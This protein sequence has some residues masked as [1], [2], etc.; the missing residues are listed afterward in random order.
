MRHILLASTVL[1]SGCG[2]AIPSAPS[3]DPQ[4]AV[5]PATMPA[6]RDEPASIPLEQC[7]YDVAYFILPQYVFERMDHLKEQCS[8]AEIAGAIFYVMACKAR[9]SEPDL[10][11]AHQYSWTSGSF[12]DTYDYLLL[13]F[14]EPAPIELGDIDPVAM[15]QAGKALTLAPHFSLVLHGSDEPLYYILGQAPIGGG[16]TLRQILRD[17][18]NANL[19]PGPA[20]AHSEFLDHVRT[21]VNKT[22]G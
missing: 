21:I 20:A 19:G 4:T 7:S 14:P 3:Q 16:T 2:G 22:A 6:I 12:N 5:S 11:A 15:L 18:I 9:D 13:S 8:Q 10:Q 17:G 1:V